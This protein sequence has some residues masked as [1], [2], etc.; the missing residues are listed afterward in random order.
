MP[1]VRAVHSAA[2]STSLATC[3]PTS[4]G[5][6]R[7][8]SPRSSAPASPDLTPSRR[9]GTRCVTSLPPR[10][11]SSAQSSTTCTTNGKPEYAAT[12]SSPRWRRCSRQRYWNDARPRGRRVGPENHPN[13]HH[14][15][16]HGHIGCGRRVRC[17]H[18]ARRTPRPGVHIKAASGKLQHRR[19]VEGWTPAGCSRK[20]TDP[21]GVTR[22]A[23]ACGGGQ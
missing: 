23:V 22:G 18:Q 13:A 1:D 15:A 11:G 9:P 2:G 16:G 20:V 3:S 14:P 8:W 17:S 12:G 4:P 21:S 10:S 7:T 5:A 6:S 19:V